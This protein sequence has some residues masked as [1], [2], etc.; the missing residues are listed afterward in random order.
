MDND[1]DKSAELSD[2]DGRWLSYDQLARL[3][4][5]DKPSAVKLAT[6]H[7]WRRRKGN[8]GQMQV[9][10][11]LGVLVP[12]VPKVTLRKPRVFKGLRSGI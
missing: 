2:E 11:P 5:I 3:R 4:R 7:R 6:R 1:T 12:N 10:V 8:T 9:C